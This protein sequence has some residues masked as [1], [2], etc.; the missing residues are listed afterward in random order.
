MWSWP[1]NTRWSTMPYSRA[2]GRGSASS[3]RIE[4]E[5]PMWLTPFRFLSAQ[6]LVMP[7]NALAT[8][9]AYVTNECSGTLG[10][11][12]TATDQVVGEIAAGKKP[13][14]IVVRAD[15]GTVYVSDQP[16]NQLVVVDIA[17]RKATDVIA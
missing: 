3:I 9:F 16:N 15:G 7:V 14:G 4:K 6:I 10:V 17:S 5:H 1:S 8:P 13:R 11:I 12:E 2:C